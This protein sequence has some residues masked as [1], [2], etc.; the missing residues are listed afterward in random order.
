MKRILLLGAIISLAGS[1]GAADFSPKAVVSRG[2]KTLDEV[3]N[4][5]WKTTIEFGGDNV[6]TIEGKTQ[7]GGPIIL[8]LSHGD[9]SMAAVCKGDKGALKTDEGWQSLQE[10]ESSQEGSARFVARVLR[11]FKAPAAEA[12]WLLG[13]AKE[14]KVADGVYSAPLSEEGAKELLVWGRSGDNGPE[15]SGAKGSVKFWLEAGFPGKYQFTVEGT[16][17]ING[18]ERDIIR[19]NTVQ[20]KDVEITKVAIPEEAAKKLQP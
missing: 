12:E 14:L 18:E 13:K 7:K 3:R 9:Q 15:V 11:S 10:A 4:Y 17:S 16:V 1:L 2:I 5:S 20:I 6:G 19:T 8:S